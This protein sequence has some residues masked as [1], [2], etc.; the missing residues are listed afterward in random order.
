[1]YF[2]FSKSKSKGQKSIIEIFENDD[3]FQ[4]KIKE[5]FTYIQTLKI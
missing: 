4:F 2:N 1:M 3:K 5:F